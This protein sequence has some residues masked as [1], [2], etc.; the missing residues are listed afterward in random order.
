MSVGQIQRKFEIQEGIII[1]PAA[2]SL[3][4]DVILIPGKIDSAKTLEEN[5]VYP[6][7]LNLTISSIF[8][9]SAG[10]SHLLHLY[11]LLAITNPER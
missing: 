4:Q 11:L 5:I 6:I 9:V 8:R 1:Y 10:Y 3:P 2:D 7:G